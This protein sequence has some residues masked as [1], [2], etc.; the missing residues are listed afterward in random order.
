MYLTTLQ[1]FP[2]RID[3]AHPRYISNLLN[4]DKMHLSIKNILYGIE[5]LFSCQ[6]AYQHDTHFVSEE[7]HSP[8]NNERKVIYTPIPL[9]PVTF[10]LFNFNYSPP[11][12]RA[13]EFYGFTFCIDPKTF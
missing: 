4:S 7:P 9:G 1:K 12:P 13:N 2:L 3:F 5:P 8:S 10:L 6:F 11:Q